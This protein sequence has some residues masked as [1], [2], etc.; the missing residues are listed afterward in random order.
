M[1]VEY[2]Y[3][4][5]SRSPV[6]L[7]GRYEYQPSRGY[8]WLQR[9]C[10]WILDRIGCQSYGEETSYEQVSIRLDSLYDLIRRQR[11]ELARNGYGIKGVI[12]GP[13][14]FS[15]LSD[16]AMRDQPF[17]YTVPVAASKYHFAKLDGMK[18]FVLPWA[19]GVTLLPDL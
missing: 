6:P 4:Q 1:S 11:N 17:M 7:P 14:E 18:L 19:K 3:M 9:A 2:F 8:S 5:E 16:W 13:E 12:L 15:K 10:F